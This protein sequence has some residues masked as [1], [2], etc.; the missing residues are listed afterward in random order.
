VNGVA[1]TNLSVGEVREFELQFQ[2]IAIFLHS[3][4]LGYIQNFL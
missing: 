2:D 3:D 4:A 1:Y